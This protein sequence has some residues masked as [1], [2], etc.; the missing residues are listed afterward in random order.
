MNTRMIVAVV[1][2]VILAFIAIWAVRDREPAVMAEPMSF[3]ECA[4][5]YP[6]INGVPRSCVTPSGT[7]FT[8]TPAVPATTTQAQ[9][10]PPATPSAPITV[11][12]PT[13]NQKV[14]SPLTVTG[15]ARGTWYFEASFPVELRNAQNQII[16]QVPAQAQGEWMTENYVPF[17]ATLTFP[18]QPAGSKGTLILRKDNP[19]GLPQHDA[20]VSVPV[21]F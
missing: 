11:S 5:Q 4:A 14:T 6:V 8:E 10:T 3:A 18:A 1:A 2:L 15:S 20:S 16:A 9:P 21:T 7:I 17:K 12:S 19:S 13:S